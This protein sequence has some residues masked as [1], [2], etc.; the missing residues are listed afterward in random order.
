MMEMFGKYQ[1]FRK[2]LSRFQEEEAGRKGNI[3]SY[4][5]WCKRNEEWNKI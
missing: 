5:V 1:Y 2:C 4:V 3:I